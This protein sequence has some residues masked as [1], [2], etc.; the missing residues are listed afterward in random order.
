MINALFGPPV[1]PTELVTSFPLDRCLLAVKERLAS[2]FNPF[3]SRSVAGFIRGTELVAWQRTGYRNSFRPLMKAKFLHSPEGTRVKCRFRM[4]IAVRIFMT[5][6]F[7]FVGLL[8]GAS[9]LDAL[10]PDAVGRAESFDSPKD[11]AAAP[12]ALIFTM[13]M[14][15]FGV[16]LVRGGR[17]LARD[18]PDFLVLFL[19]QTLDAEELPPASKA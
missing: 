10:L 12:S 5:I 14:L 4:A 3:S 8:A 2:P 1:P 19:L 11:G 16:V 15:A 18:E 6:W 7:G 17:W 9:A 13:L